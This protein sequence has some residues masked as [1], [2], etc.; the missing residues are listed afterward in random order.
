MIVNDVTVTLVL[1]Q[2]NPQHTVPTLVDNGFALWESRAIITY[3]ADQYGKNDSLYPK[4]AKK[5]ALV[6]QRLYFDIGTLY[7]RFSDYYV[8]LSNKTHLILMGLN[9]RSIH[10]CT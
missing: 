5:R 1:L 6:N 2:I 3:L 8:S 10:T 7:A 9:T 4:D